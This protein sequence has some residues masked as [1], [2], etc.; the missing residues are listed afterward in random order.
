MR[1][2]K[3]PFCM[4]VG[5]VGLALIQRLTTNS[6]MAYYVLIGIFFSVAVMILTTK[7]LPYFFGLIPVRRVC[8]TQFLYTPSLFPSNAGLLL[9]FLFREL[10]LPLLQCLVGDLFMKYI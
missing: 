4:N 6:E 9:S 7:F 3:T 8:K 10:G 2:L 1:I 5:G